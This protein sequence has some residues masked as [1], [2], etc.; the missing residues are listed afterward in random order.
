MPATRVTVTRSAAHTTRQRLLVII[1][2]HRAAYR[3]TYACSCTLHLRLVEASATE[4]TA[5]GWTMDTGVK[6]EGREKQ[7]ATVST[8]LR[9]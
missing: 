7:D 4:A 3:C 8:Y 5:M 1:S 2:R 6:D 9:E